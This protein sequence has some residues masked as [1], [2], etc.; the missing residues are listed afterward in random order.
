MAHQRFDAVFIDFYGTLVTGDRN[1]VESTSAQIISDHALS[2]SASQ[3]TEVWGRRFFEEIENANGESFKN[4][5]ACECDSLLAALGD[6]VS[7]L[8]PAPYADMLKAY[9]CDPPIADGVVEGLSAIEVPTYIV[10]NADTDDVRSAMQQRGIKTTGVV[11]SEDARSYKPDSGIFHAALEMAG[12]SAERV[13]HVGDS[14]H[15]DVGG[16]KALGMTACWVCYE[17]RILD[18]GVADPCHKI[19]SIKDLGPLLA[20]DTVI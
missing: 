17:D 7:N 2:M 1:A 9:W 20:T 10:S 12:T 6:H 5:Y 19:L 8:D 16:A 13:I 14:L 15:S 11:T 3:L 18:I 4:L